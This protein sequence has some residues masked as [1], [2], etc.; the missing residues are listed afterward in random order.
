MKQ[1][2]I[3]LVASTLLFTACKDDGDPSDN[4]Q[5]RDKL[6]VLVEMTE[7]YDIGT[8]IQHYFSYD[9]QGRLISKRTLQTFTDGQANTDDTTTY[10]YENNVI[11]EQRFAHKKP[12]ILQLNDDGLLTVLNRYNYSIDT[13]LPQ[14]YKYDDAQRLKTISEPDSVLK[15]AIW[16]GDDLVKITSVLYGNEVYTA[17]IVPSTLT[18][19]GFYPIEL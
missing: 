6:Y 11:T 5:D 4:S 2:F 13:Y 1:F 15:T 7:D 18:T 19:S 12:Y 14:T 3:M 8:F 10:T 9:K 16:N 17:T